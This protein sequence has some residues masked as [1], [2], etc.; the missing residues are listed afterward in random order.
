MGGGGRGGGAPGQEEKLGT[1]SLEP[2]EIIPLLSSYTALGV[3][4]LP[5][6]PAT[7]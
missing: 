1:K 5:N 3:C 4:L 6:V 2:T 7:C